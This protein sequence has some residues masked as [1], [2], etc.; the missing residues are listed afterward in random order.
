MASSSAQERAQKLLQTF[1]DA[2]SNVLV[3]DEA[4]G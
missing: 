2:A 3:V 4:F 1:R